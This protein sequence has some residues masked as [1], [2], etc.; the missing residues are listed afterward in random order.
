MNERGV[1][2]GLAILTCLVWI[3]SVGPGSVFQCLGTLQ[4][5]LCDLDTHFP[6]YSAYV[7]PSTEGHVFTDIRPFSSRV[8]DLET[9]PWPGVV[10][11][12]A[13]IV[14]KSH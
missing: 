14:L 3:A 2:G 5:E 6:A 11:S 1:L 13:I 8:G 12:P 4:L 9:L 10:G 7:I